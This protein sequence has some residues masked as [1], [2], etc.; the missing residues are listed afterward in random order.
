MLV[1]TMRT[2]LYEVEPSDPASIA[3]V[4][5]VLLATALVACWRPTRQAMRVDPVN[6]LREG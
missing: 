5:A 1:Q 4:A 3:A 6:L 2:L